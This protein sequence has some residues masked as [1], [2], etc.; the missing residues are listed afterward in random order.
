MIKVNHRLCHWCRKKRGSAVYYGTAVDHK[1]WQCPVAIDESRS[2]SLY[3]AFVHLTRESDVPLDC[4][5][6]IEHDF[7]R[8]KVNFPFWKMRKR[9]A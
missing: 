5:Y 2:T 1:R 3:V 6:L 9:D 4:P 8:G 7:T